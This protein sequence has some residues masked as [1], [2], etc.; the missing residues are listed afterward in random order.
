[1]KRIL[2]QI[3]LFAAVAGVA[4]LSTL[5]C[6]ELL[7]TARRSAPWSERLGLSGEQKG[8]VA[9]LEKGFLAQSQ[10]TCGTLCAKRAQMITLLEQENPDRAALAAVVEE[11][12]AEQLDME[13]ATL[14]HVLAVASRMDSPQRERYFARVREELRSACK[15]TACGA[16]GVCLAKR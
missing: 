6:G 4:Y 7:R 13:K 11:I 9:S 2:V 14:D 1:M 10:A 5:G 15:G 16:S 8:R 12:G 3:G